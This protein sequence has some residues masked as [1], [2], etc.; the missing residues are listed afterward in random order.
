MIDTA[1]KWL[2]I[3]E[4]KIEQGDLIEKSYEGELDGK[5]G[6]LLLSKKKILFVRE[7]GIIHKSYNLDLDL[8]YDKIGMISHKGRFKLEVIEGKGKKY[9]FKSWEVLAEKVEEGIDSLAH[10]R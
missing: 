1:P 9:D 3:A 5:W 2:D 7:E 8:P 10:L 6:H 4:K